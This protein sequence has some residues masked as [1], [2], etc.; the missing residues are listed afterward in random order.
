MS[1]MCNTH[2]HC[3]PCLPRLGWCIDVNLYY[4]EAQLPFLLCATPSGPM[5]LCSI[6]LFAKYHIAFVALLTIP[7]KLGVRHH[8]VRILAGPRANGKSLNIPFL[9]G[10]TSPLPMHT[11]HTLLF[12]SAQKPTV[13]WLSR[14]SPQCCTIANVSLQLESVQF[15]F[16]R[17]ER[18]QSNRQQPTRL[19]LFKWSTIA[20]P[21][22]GVMSCVSSPTVF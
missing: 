19:G 22:P 18:G 5:S 16:V 7:T 12:V 6:V 14:V 9:S 3:V 13:H 4:Y 2:T 17:F 11:T 8:S 21:S 20:A 15:W 10:H 1:A